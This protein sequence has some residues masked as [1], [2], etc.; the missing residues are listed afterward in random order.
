MAKVCKKKRQTNYVEDIAAV[1]K[2]DEHAEHRSQF[3]VS[4]VLEN[5]KVKFN[6]DYDAAVTLVSHDWLKMIFP[7][8]EMFETQLKLKSFCE[9]MFEP[10]GFVR[11]KINDC[12]TIK[13]LNMYV[14]ESNREP[15]GREWINQLNSLKKLKDSLNEIQ[16]INLVEQ[17]EIG[18]IKNLLN[19]FPNLTKE[20][21]APIKGITNKCQTGYK[22]NLFEK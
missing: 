9:V 17:T 2:S 8:L 6:V 7:K 19:E 15:L 11:V 18:I 3:M 4:L 13:T 10:I 22:T 12:N 21:F 20:E 1:E 16:G 14:V 5:K